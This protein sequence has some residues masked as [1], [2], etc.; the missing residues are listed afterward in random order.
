MRTLLLLAFLVSFNISFAQNAK[1]DTS[2]SF[3][4]IGNKWLPEDRAIPNGS[5]S[6]LYVS[7]PYQ[8][9][10]YENTAIYI[11]NTSV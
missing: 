2:I 6:P 11:M 5:K 8:N 3:F 1:W 9:D 10:K 4:R 7:I